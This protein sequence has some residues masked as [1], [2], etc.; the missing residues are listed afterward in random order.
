MA[1]S[2]SR[3]QSG[4]DTVASATFLH[5]ARRRVPQW[6]WYMLAAFGFALIVVLTQLV[7]FLRRADPRD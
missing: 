4:A 6:A 7:L 1:T 5:R 3:T 2:A